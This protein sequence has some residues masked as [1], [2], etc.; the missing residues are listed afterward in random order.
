METDKAL[1]VSESIRST[2]SALGPGARSA[3]FSTDA[4][5][6]FW[7]RQCTKPPT[8]SPFSELPD[9]IFGMMREEVMDTIPQVGARGIL[10]AKYSGVI[11][12]DSGVRSQVS[13][14]VCPGLLQQFDPDVTEQFQ[15]I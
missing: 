7:S 3:S 2:G 6:I 11:G 15:A 14:R 1:Q 12:D 9:G 5:A 10:F 8:V 4:G 13:N